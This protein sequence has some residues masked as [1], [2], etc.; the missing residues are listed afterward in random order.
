M[1]L[2]ELIGVGAFLIASVLQ[3]YVKKIFEA[4]LVT[5]FIST[6]IF[7]IA[8]TIIVNLASGSETSSLIQSASIDIFRFA[9][10]RFFARSK[11]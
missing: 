10:I 7:V 4:W 8:L 9:A 2:I 6:V 3:F 5:S 1:G 11:S